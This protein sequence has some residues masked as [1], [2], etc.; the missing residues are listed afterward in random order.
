MPKLTEVSKVV[1]LAPDH[2]DLAASITEIEPNVCANGATL[3]L[4]TGNAQIEFAT[5]KVIL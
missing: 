2:E 3:N 1:L 4:G 5:T